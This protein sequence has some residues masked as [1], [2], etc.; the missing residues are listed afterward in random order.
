MSST[1]AASITAIN[2]NPS[3]ENTYSSISLEAGQMVEGYLSKMR[4][5]WCEST[6]NVSYS[7]RFDDIDVALDELVGKTLT[8]EYTGRIHC[9]ACG[10]KTNKSFNQGHCYPCFKKLASC[11]ICIVSPEKCHFDQGTCR[12]PEWAQQF[13]MNDHVVYLANSSSAKV[14]ITRI[15]QLP[16]RWMDQ[17][18]TQ[19]LPIFRVATRQQ[20]GLVETA[21]K[22]FIADKTNWRALLKGDAEPID[23]PMLR[24]TLL[25]KAAS[26][27]DELQQLYGDMAIQ[28]LDQSP[29][30]LSYPVQKHPTKIVSHN[31][32]KQPVVTGRLEGIKGQYLLFDTGVINIRKF[33]AYHCQLSVQS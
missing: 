6:G 31:L 14:G 4:N 27:I 15:T 2:V 22:P 25:E 11:D 13:C 19:A 18:A 8:L 21:L 29:V 9:T 16:T 32:D 7:M 17:G 20:A 5:R 30:T 26:S 33:T 28:S 1:P 23:L 24:D 3:L 12:E 10:R